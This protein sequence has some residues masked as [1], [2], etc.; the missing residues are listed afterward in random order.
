MLAVLTTAGVIPAAGQDTAVAADSAAAVPDT[1][2]PEV[3]L[4]SDRAV[5]AAGS[6]FTLTATSTTPVENLGAALEIVESSSGAVVK[7][8]Y[9]G[10]ECSKTLT[11]FT[12][13]GREYIARVAYQQ[14]APVSVSRLPWT[15]DL[16]VDKAVLAAGETY[17]VQATANQSVGETSGEYRIFIV[18][19]TT[20]ATVAQCY[21]SDT[22]AT[23]NLRYF[24]GLPH[25]YRAFVASASNVDVDVQAS[26]NT[27]DGPMRQAWTVDL[28]VDKAVVAAGESYS[29]TATANQDVGETSGNYWIY[30]VDTTTGSLVTRCYDWDVCTAQNLRVFS[31]EPHLYQAYVASPA[32]WDVDVQATS[33]TLA[34]ATRMPWTIELQVDK[35][36]FAAGESF[37]LTATAN[38]DVGAT[39]G[40]Y[41]MYIVD[42]TTGRVVSKCYTSV[43]CSAPNQRYLTGVADTY[44]AFVASGGGPDSDVQATSSSIAGPAREAWTVELSV[45]KTTFAAGEPPTLTATTN[46]D[47]GATD[48]TFWIYIVDLNS[49][50]VI[51]KC[52]YSYTCST[53]NTLFFTGGPHT[54]QAYVASAS[55]PHLDIQA[56]SGSVTTVRAPWAIQLVQLSQSAPDENGLIEIAFR[57]DAN[58]DIGWTHGDYRVWLYDVTLGAVLTSCATL[59]S[60]VYSI[61]RPTGTFERIVAYVASTTSPFVD[62]QATSNG[63]SLPNGTGAILPGETQGGA[64]PAEACAGT[65]VADPVNPLSGE[66]FESTTD[67]ALPGV[68]P[69]VAWTRNYSTARAGQ[70]STMGY[71]WVANVGASLQS[72]DGSPLQTA[73]QLRVV[74][75]NGSATTFLR[76]EADSFAPPSRVFATL[77]R[78]DSGRFKYV[79]GSDEVF[80]FSA[81][82]R[83]LRVEDLN[84]N[85]VDLTYNADGTVKKL[86]ADDGRSITASYTAGRVATVTDSS[87]REVD[88]EYSSAGD[89]VAIG[90]FS[91]AASTYG[92]DA[93]HRVV[94]M[95]K[96]GNA[97]T[98]NQY[99]SSGRVIRQVDPIGRETLFAYQANATL[100]TDNLGAVTRQEYAN[101]QLIS[102]TIAFGTSV[103]ATTTY[104]YTANNQ[105]AS[106]TDPLGRITYNGYD[107]RGNLIWT[108]DP[109]GAMT[110]FTYND[111]GQLL[112]VTNALQDVTSFEYDAHGNATAVIDALGNRTQNTVDARGLVTAVTDALGNTTHFTLDARGHRIAATSPGGVV[113]KYI[114]DALGLT[115]GVVDPRGTRPGANPEDYTTTYAY[116][117]SGDPLEVTDADG[118]STVY[119]YDDA[120]HVTRSTD[121]L[122]RVTEFQYDKAGQLLSSTDPAGGTTTYSYDGVGRLTSVTSPGGATATTVY[123]PAGR[124]TSTRDA[125]GEVTTNTYD[126]AGQLLTTTSPEGRTVT[127]QYDAAGRVTCVTDPLGGKTRTGYNSIGKPVK[128]TD[129]DGRITLSAYDDAGRLL[130]ST[131]NDGAIESFAYDA[132]GRVTDHVDL[133]GDST[134]YEYDVDGNVTSTTDFAGRTTTLT[135][136]DGYPVESTDATGESSTTTY[137]NLGRVATVSY[138][139]AIDPTHYQYDAL[140]RVTSVSEDAGTTTYAYDALD[141]VTGVTG[142]T[143]NVGYE[144]DNAGNLAQ[145]TYPSGRTVDREYDAMGRLT[146]LSTS[147][148][149]T[150]SFGWS[151]DGLLSNVDMPNSVDTDYEYDDA[152]RLATQSTS[153]ASSSVLDLD[154]GYTA[155]GLLDS[156]TTTRAGGVPSTE[157]VTWDAAGRMSTISSM[158][159]ALPVK[160]TAASAVTRTDDGSALT[161]ATDRSLESVTR[162]TEVT[163]FE[164]DDLGRRTSA[165]VGDDAATTVSYSWDQLGQLTGI[166]DASSSTDTDYSYALGLRIG[167]TVTRGSASATSPYQWDTV[168]AV[169]L[170]LSDGTDEFI[171]GVGS[172]PVAQVDSTTGGV[173][174]LTADALGSTRAATDESGAVVGTWDYSAFGL[175]TAGSGGVADD[176]AGVTRFLFA[177]EYRDDSG[178]YYLRARFYDPATASFLSVDPAFGISGCAYGYASG[179]PLQL[180]DPLGLFSLS[181]VGNWIDDHKGE[182]IGAVV[183]IGVTVG[184][185]AVTAGAGSVACAA[186]GGAV[187]GAVT[188]GINT[189]KDC[190]TAGGFFK[191]ATF[192][193]ALGGATA[194]VGNIVGPWLRFAVMP[195]IVGRLSPVLVEVEEAVVGSL[196][197]SGRVAGAVE[198]SVESLRNM[199]SQIRQSGLHP[200]ARNNRTIAVGQDDA[201]TLYAGSSNGFDAGQRAALE[202][203]GIVRVPGSGGLHAEEELLREVPQLARVGTSVRVPCGPSEKNC[204][205]QLLARGVQVK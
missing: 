70:S 94:T 188:Y 63:L 201:G 145:V 61:R 178:L 3:E 58:Q 149:G 184:C 29:L 52:Y 193:A 104:T 124:P 79:R 155:A 183:G 118:N 20:G 22:C 107:Y 134:S 13:P 1:S 37:T 59:S 89:L 25:T 203:L 74:Q 2:V 90:D 92:Y 200:I 103:A 173:T 112:T 195:A 135:Y 169:P 136:T 117:L 158:V 123:D 51:A 177:G 44:Q 180:V 34:G 18:D 131:R 197:R 152:G 196:P 109:M 106:V 198:E 99:D 31:G 140:G 142:P 187:G 190:W 76:T 167:A 186:L 139:S 47:V 49:G 121:A 147:D 40:S 96:P 80:L 202:Q 115:T 166:S 191:A 12:G 151:A 75:E 38:Q 91:G 67:L 143:G 165:T 54:Y 120:G 50:D 114:V 161:W 28:A 127:Y 43:V 60:C 163:S 95:T 159:S 66:F 23:P 181:S 102:S 15:L 130:S 21:Y 110:S 141:R 154:Y 194:G 205:A 93:S 27:V 192:G 65:C 122:G 204:M 9:T 153:S 175:V 174:F 17:K 156:R 88:Y 150:I 71:G 11:F 170:L 160:Y 148:V 98:T 72:V 108:I 41:W 172:S 185:L 16:D 182:I 4:E 36:T 32:G 26:S 30:I 138:S 176:G 146:N 81:T 87:G 86:E 78:L 48:G 133:N 35:S 73:T 82:G 129:A 7:S 57:G 10:T 24:T 97:V 179:N 132:L 171:Y 55:N 125:A 189:P 77:E 137:D 46:Q 128:V 62:I 83:L 8:C 111:G 68:G 126:A 101:A 116:T 56:A 39:N 199:A 144:Y 85:G 69:S 105:V 113:T 164:A 53:Q 157:S 162:G 33:N 168:S 119:D 14:S 84:G 6:T 100:I 64:N 5:F 19:T 45:D 42:T